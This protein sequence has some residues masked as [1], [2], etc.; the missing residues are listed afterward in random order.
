MAN[1]VAYHVH[2]DDS[3]LDSCTK[4]SDYIDKAVELGQTA[5]AITNHGNVYNWLERKLYAEERGITI[6]PEIDLPGHMQAALASY[7]ELGCK[8][9]EPPALRGLD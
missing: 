4:Y 1:Y 6:I 8:G 3:L 5:I 9:S 7:P 2:D